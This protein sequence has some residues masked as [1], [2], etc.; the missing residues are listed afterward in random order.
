MDQKAPAVGLTGASPYTPDT[1]DATD[2]RIQG[3][4]FEADG[5]ITSFSQSKSPVVGVDNPLY[6]ETGLG[7]VPEETPESKEESGC[8]CHVG[9]SRGG[10]PVVVLLLLMGF[11]AILRKRKHK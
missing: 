5:I 7:L 1:S 11:V 8:G 9:T 3:L 10:R 4:I 6:P 2:L